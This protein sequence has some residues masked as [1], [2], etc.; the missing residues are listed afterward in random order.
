MLAEQQSQLLLM[1]SSALAVYQEALN[2]DDLGMAVATATKVLEGT[3]ALNKQDFSHIQG[4]IHSAGSGN[5]QENSSTHFTK[6]LEGARP[7]EAPAPR[8][9]A[10]PILSDDR[11]E[12][13]DNS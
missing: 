10:V 2:S 6:Q 11:T 7:D 5:R 9:S 13:K 8:E 4:N 1:G 3:G 12:D